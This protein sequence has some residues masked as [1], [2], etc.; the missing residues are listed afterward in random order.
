[1]NPSSGPDP[2]LDRPRRL[3]GRGGNIIRKENGKLQERH[4]PWH[5]GD[6]PSPL[7]APKEQA[8][9]GMG[10]L[11][12]GSAWN[13][14][15]EG[16]SGEPRLRTVP[17]VKLQLRKQSLAFPP[18]V[19]RP[20]QPS[21]S[22][23]GHYSHTAPFSGQLKRP[24]GPRGALSSRCSFQSKPTQ[25]GA[26]IWSRAWDEA[27]ALASSRAPPEPLQDK[28][29]PSTLWLGRTQRPSKPQRRFPSSKATL[30]QGRHSRQTPG[31]NPPEG[32]GTRFSSAK[33]P[34]PAP[35]WF[36]PSQA[37]WAHRQGHCRQG[38]VGPYLSEEAQDETKPSV[39][40]E[41]SRSIPQGTSH[42]SGPPK[43]RSLLL[44]ALSK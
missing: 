43:R 26:G 9:Q 12:L 17:P 31:G 27:L 37:P 18:C 11:S 44:P 6:L 2:A 25:E 41:R 21:P 32:M 20:S 13:L 8:G 14:K 29:N 42:L 3:Q 1:M 34:Q 30:A 7:P 22:R 38:S 39:D 5:P 24:Y 40:E 23:Q 16:G 15:Q 33:I 36:V 10:Q 4:Q 19:N 28:S 35:R